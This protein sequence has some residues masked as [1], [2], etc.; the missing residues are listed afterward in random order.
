MWRDFLE[1]LLPETF[2]FTMREAL[3]LASNE[4]KVRI[5]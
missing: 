4:E 3:R 5:S 2:A 1:K